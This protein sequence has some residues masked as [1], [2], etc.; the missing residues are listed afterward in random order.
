MLD[1][2]DSKILKARQAAFLRRRRREPKQ[3]DFVR[4]AD[5]VLR[6]I[7]HVW[8]DSNGD[9]VSVQTS[10]SNDSSFYLG[11]GYM[12]FSGS[13]YPGVPP[14]TLKRTKERMPGSCWFFHH[15]FARAH[16]GVYVKVDCPVWECSLSSR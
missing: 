11:L 10:Y 12:E 6:R 1:K 14:E 15:D 3:G 16:N 7:A 13:L 5:G 2:I 9:V 4:F 8:T